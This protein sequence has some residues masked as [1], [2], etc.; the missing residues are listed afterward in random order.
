M[1]KY[2]RV[3]EILGRHE[4]M[5]SQKEIAEAWGVSVQYVS[6]IEKRALKH[7]KQKLAEKGIYFL[8]DITP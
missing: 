3:S 1:S 8:E 2:I 6:Y 4:F 7:F 5:R